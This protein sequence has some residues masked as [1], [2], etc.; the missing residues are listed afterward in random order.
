[1]S[2]EIGTPIPG[3]W[4]EE[5]DGYAVGLFL[6]PNSPLWGLVV[7]TVLRVLSRGRFWRRDSGTI[8]DAQDAGRIAYMSFT[9]VSFQSLLDAVAGVQVAIENLKLAT[10]VSV[11]CC[12]QLDAPDPPDPPP[13]PLPVPDDPGVDLPPA[14][15]DDA[16]YDTEICRS[17]NA[18]HWLVSRYLGVVATLDGIAAAVA[19]IVALLAVAFPEGAT[20]AIGGVTLATI[21]SAMLVIEGGLTAV[22]SWAGLARDYWDSKQQEFVCAMYVRIGGAEDWKEGVAAFIRSAV[23]AASD[24]VPAS[25]AERVVS[26]VEPFLL[27]L[28]DDIYTFSQS[29]ESHPSPVSCAACDVLE[30]GDYI[31]VPVDIDYYVGTKPAWLS[32]NGNTFIHGATA[33]HAGHH[34]MLKSVSHDGTVVGIAMRLREISAAVAPLDFEFIPNRWTP[35]QWSGSDLAVLGFDEADDGRWGVNVEPGES[36]AVVTALSDLGFFA[37]GAESFNNDYTQ[38]YGF[39]WKND[40]G[41]AAAIEVSLYLVFKVAGA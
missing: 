11:A 10:S 29:L 24:A 18:L 1:M 17:A 4:N 32:W 35:G 27:W 9:Y 5:A 36:V 41:E 40:R 31:F 22:A 13:A 38:P 7:R 28:E 21:A 15:P 23:V 12:D 3:D 39:V 26:W 20:T 8:K 6:F 19:V 37:S 25:F 16:S 34:I 30:S 33:D 2:W 14:Y